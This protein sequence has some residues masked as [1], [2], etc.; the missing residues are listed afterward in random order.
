MMARFAAAVL[1]LILVC[2]FGQFAWRAMTGHGVGAQTPA[3]VATTFPAG[4]P[5]VAV[6]APAGTPAAPPPVAA[7][8][9]S[10][11]QSPAAPAATPPSCTAGEGFA[12]AAAQNAASLDT[13]PVAPFG[14]PEVGWEVYLPLTAHEIGSE[15][16]PQSPGFA[17]ALAAWQKGHGVAA[18]GVMDAP[19]LEA[20]R[21]VWL[22]RRPFVAA[23]GHGL[24]PP[25]PTPNRL[26]WSTA[27]EAYGA[28]PVQ[29]RPGAL[30]AYRAMVAAA[31]HDVP[32]L[33]ADPALL[34]IFSGY[35]DPIADAVRCVTEGNCGSAVRAN[36]SAHRTGLAMDIDLGSAPGYRVDSAADPNRLYM[37]RLP[38]YR[39]LVAN[40]GRFGFVNYP[41]E[42]WHW[43]WVGE[44]P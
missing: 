9:F 34:T 12:Q 15:C 20:L 2:A 11:P 5:D 13:A 42:P 33:A 32:T 44:A 25:A 14:R 40:A 23:S 41:F 26:A 21:L 27:K 16:P 1:G 37:S 18:N 43:E 36:C 22:R 17:Q 38:A 7:Q 8:T 4:P 6:P 19:T 39:W 29:L 3:P 31:R 24:C 30:N 10:S 35:R 28:R